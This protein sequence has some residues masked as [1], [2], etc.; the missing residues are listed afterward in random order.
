MWIRS[1]KKLVSWCDLRNSEG[2]R[3]VVE[4]LM[5]LGGVLG[6]NVRTVAAIGATVMDVD[7]V[8]R[9]AAT[10]VEVEVGELRSSA[11]GKTRTSRSR[12]SNKK[13]PEHSNGGRSQKL[14]QLD[15]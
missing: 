11:R 5:A 8:L 12:G 3:T 4:A 13:P 9:F 14:Y 1:K 15:E 2:R 6:R 7:G 10:G